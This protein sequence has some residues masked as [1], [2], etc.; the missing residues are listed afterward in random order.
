MIFT[1]LDN[2][3]ILH[4]KISSEY[5]WDHRDAPHSELLPAN[6]GFVCATRTYTITTLSPVHT[7]NNVEATFDFVAKNCSNVERVFREISSFWRCWNKLNMFNLFRLSPKDEISFDIV[8]KK[9]QQ[10]RSNVRRCRKN[11]STCIAFDD[12]VASTLLLVW[13]RL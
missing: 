8:A 12:S 13:T 1:S 9:Q 2:F 10:R 11:R 3:R 4:F 6:P 7:S 5:A